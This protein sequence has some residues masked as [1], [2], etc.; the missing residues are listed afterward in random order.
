[1]SLEDTTNELANIRYKIAELKQ[2]EEVYMLVKFY[3]DAQKMLIRK[4]EI[5][6]NMILH[7]TSILERFI[8]EYDYFI[9]DIKYR[10][11]DK[12]FKQLRN[13]HTNFRTDEYL[14]EYKVIAEI[15]AGQME[16]KERGQQFFIINKEI[17]PENFLKQINPDYAIKYL[18]YGLDKSLPIHDEQKK[19]KY[20]I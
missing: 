3:H 19:T 4:D 2:F 15:I 17:T 5:Q 11:E 12:L 14:K 10:G 9:D 1:M 18:H 8:T 16:K 6:I 7:S 20:K 13:S